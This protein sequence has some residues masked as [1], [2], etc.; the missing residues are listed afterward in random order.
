[1]TCLVL[2]KGNKWKN[3]TYTHTR[4]S[5]LNIV[6]KLSKQ[7]GLKTNCSKP[8]LIQNLIENGNINNFDIINSMNLDDL[9]RLCGYLGIQK[10][11]INDDVVK[12]IIPFINEDKN[13]MK[14]T[15]D[16]R[17]DIGEL[18]NPAFEDVLS[19]IYNW[20]PAKKHRNE[21]GYTVDLEAY[22]RLI[23]KFN[24]QFEA[25][26]SNTDILVSQN[27]AIELKKSPSQSEYDRLTG[28]VKRQKRE[29]GFVIV[30]ICDPKNRDKFEEFKSDCEENNV[31]V[32][33]I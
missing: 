32:F 29:F 1:M 24:T 12:R 14:R 11:G 26:T 31:R 21:E 5:N 15:F 6:K 19:A 8:Q 3:W 9:K 10:S 16:N 20:K 2:K 13:E 17:M 33:R 28:Q 30:L 23:M 25:G 18:N 7:K 22:L 4:N 27:I